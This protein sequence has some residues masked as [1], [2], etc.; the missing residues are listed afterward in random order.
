VGVA[1]SGR[2]TGSSQIFV[3]LGPYPHLDGDYALIGRAEPGWDALAQ[4][5]LVRKVT[6]Q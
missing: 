4:G 2:D 3:T 6:V 5:D 1:L